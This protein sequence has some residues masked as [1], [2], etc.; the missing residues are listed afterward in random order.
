MA[1]YVWSLVAMVLGASCRPTSFEQYWL[2]VQHCLPGGEGGA[3][4][5]KLA[6][7]C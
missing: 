5:E 6:A 2:W 4:Y 1:K 7:I 3:L